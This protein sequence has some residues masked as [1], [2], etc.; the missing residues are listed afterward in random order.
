MDPKKCVVCKE[1]PMKY[2]CPR[3]SRR[4]CSLNC[5]VEHKKTFHCN[6]Q[7]DRTSFKPLA[8]MSDLDLLS[9]YRLLEEVQR[10][11]ETGGRDPLVNQMKSFNETT[12]HEK[13]LQNKLKASAA[14][15]LLFLPK[16]S[17]RHK[18]NRMTFDRRSDEILWHV[19]CRFFSPEAP[20]SFVTWS[21]VRLRTSE[22]TLENLL[23]KAPNDVP[24]EKNDVAVYTENF[25][26]QRKQNGKFEKSASFETFVELF[27]Q[28]TFIEF[29]ILF[30]CRS[31]DEKAMLEKLS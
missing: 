8:T 25:G 14:I 20:K 18:E 6:G 26:Q 31:S 9:D 23:A 3:C 15:R 10:C 27:R 21:I 29:P 11:V 16:F 1:N 13:F 30:L 2:T 19:E 28:R 12:R 22:T 7:R 17:S 24:K 4:T 5:C